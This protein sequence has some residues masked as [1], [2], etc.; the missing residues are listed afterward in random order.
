[1]QF[2]MIISNTEISTNSKTEFLIGIMYK[3]HFQFKIM[4][5][6]FFYSFI[7]VMLVKFLHITQKSK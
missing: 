7:Y 3:N 2:K 6:I 5:C 4:H 1:M